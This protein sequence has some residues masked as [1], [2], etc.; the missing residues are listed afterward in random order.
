VPDRFET[1][2]LRKI[3]LLLILCC[4]FFGVRAQVT[5]GQFAMEYLRLPNAP[6]ISA[7][8]GVNVADAEGDIA[9]AL[10]NPA[11]M[12]PG[13]HNQLDLNYNS[14]YAGIQIMNLQY[15]YNVPQLNTA[16]F[17][18]VQYLN[19]GAVQHTDNTGNIFENF[20]PV[21]YAITIGGSRTYGEHWRY[22]AA[23]KLAHSFLYSNSATA[24]LT[25]IG[26]NYYDSEN[27]WDFGACAKNMGAMLIEYHRGNNEPLPFDLQL[28]ISKQLKH[29]PLKLFV[30]IHHLYE[31]DVM[32][33]DPTDAT[34]TNVLGTT[35]SAAS[36]SSNFADLLFRH[37]IFGAELS[38][39]KKISFT[40]SYNYMQRK[41]LSIDNYA[42]ITGFAFG[43]NV[44]LKKMQLHY[45]RSF[46][47]ITGAYNELGITLELNKL[48]GLGNWG[49][50]MGWNSIYT[51]YE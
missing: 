48:M 18:G 36:K 4:N 31:W 20:S 40:A 35:D 7:L 45:A 49:E 50:K 16:F 28:G 25:D 33:N 5:G 32:Y 47:H 8:G 46:Y 14:Y 38:L 17:L 24:A 39:A 2:R 27:L 3:Y 12:R 37:F 26:I 43:V 6:H 51:D 10:Q 19:Y 15:G 13:L 42:G 23:L 11:L 44:Y 30:T 22:G 21:D 1:M 9:F 29:V 34:S 41:E